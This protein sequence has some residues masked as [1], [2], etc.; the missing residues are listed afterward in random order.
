[1]N[2]RILINDKE[3]GYSELEGRD[4]GMGIFYG[5]FTP[6]PGYENFRSI[7]RLYIEAMILRDNH[8]PYEEKLNEFYKKRELLRVTVEEEG[9]KT[10]PVV[11]VTIVDVFVEFGYYD[12]EVILSEAD[13]ITENG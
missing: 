13:F 2:Y 9:G 5:N 3:I 7:F 12:V 4:Y 8:Q 6:T 10:I 1:M 11:A